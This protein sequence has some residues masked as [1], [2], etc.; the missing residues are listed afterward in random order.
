[1]VGHQVFIEL[2]QPW[3]AIWGIH[4]GSAGE[5]VV[6]DQEDSSFSSSPLSEVQKVT[7]AATAA[8]AAVP[9]EATPDLIATVVQQLDTSQQK[10]EAVAAAVDALPREAKPELVATIVQTLDSLQQQRAAAEAVMSVLPTEQNLITNENGEK[11]PAENLA[12]AELVQFIVKVFGADIRQLHQIAVRRGMTVTD[13]L[14]QCITAQNWIDQQKHSHSSFIVE[15][16]HG[17]RR[18]VVFP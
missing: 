17:N 3:S 1:V 7:E 16:S 4:V 11:V 6:S 2:L 5:A 10:L 15:D 18:R 9:N 12:P 8:A 13:A 14:R